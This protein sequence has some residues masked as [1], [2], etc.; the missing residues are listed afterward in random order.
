M[1]NFNLI[2]LVYV[3]PTILCLIGYTYKTYQD[4]KRDKG[5]ENLDYY[6]VKLTWGDIVLRLVASF[7]PVINIFALIVD[8]YTPGL[9]KLWEKLTYYYNKPVINNNNK[10]N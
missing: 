9:L 8:L 3:L 2:L 5:R 1:I 10:P 4:Y 7:M 6:I